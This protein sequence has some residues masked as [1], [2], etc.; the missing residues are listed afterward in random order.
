MSFIKQLL[1][2][3]SSP[4]ISDDEYQYE[5]WLALQEAAEQAE[6]FKIFENTNTYP[7]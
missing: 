6:F 7:F 4:I 1:D 2:E 5:E 3:N